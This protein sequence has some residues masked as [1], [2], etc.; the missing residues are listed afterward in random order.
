MLKRDCAGRIEG[1]R[2]MKHFLRTGAVLALLLLAGCYR[3][4]GDAAIEPTPNTGQ[5]A[6]PLAPL[7]AVTE[8]SVPDD[9][10][11]ADE[12]EPEEAVEPMD[13]PTQTNAPAQPAAGT[14]LTFPPITIISPTR[15]VGATP[16][17]ADGG[18]EPAANGTAFI[19]PGMGLAPITPD[20]ATPTPRGG[21]LTATPSGLITPTA[22]VEEVGECEYVVQ[23]GDNLFRIAINNDITLAELRAA[24]P[25]LV[26]ENPIIQVGDR[27]NLPNCAPEAEAEEPA[28]PI[29][30][31]PEGITPVGGAPVAPPAQ[32]ELYTVQPGDTLYAIAV[33][34]GT[35][36]N[37]IVQANQ[38]ANPND[39]DVG[40]ELVIPAG[41]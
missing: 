7:P 4:A 12:I 5:E 40:Q 10:I 32:G 29:I 35:T 15:Q 38:L 33:R 34:F 41:N 31:A 2:V 30:D 8:A 13:A 17:A 16:T 18:A 24:N 14:T 19:T 9:L 28:A 22:L 23:P 3:P 37:A 21:A 27:L 39:L 1:I 26:G 25:D 36:I 6:A 20:T 11:P